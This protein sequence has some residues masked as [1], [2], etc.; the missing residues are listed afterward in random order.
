M[1]NIL[2]NGSARNGSSNFLVSI[3]TKRF[4]SPS[5]NVHSSEKVADEDARIGGLPTDLVNQQK[6]KKATR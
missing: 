1:F 5:Q 6:I 4:I 3:L 2:K